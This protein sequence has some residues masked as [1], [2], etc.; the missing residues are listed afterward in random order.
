MEKG[1]N[2]AGWICSIVLLL[3]GAFGLLA[4]RGYGGYAN[5]LEFFGAFIVLGLAVNPLLL[6]SVK[7]FG[8]AYL[9]IAAGV[10]IAIAMVSY[11]SLH[12]A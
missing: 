5:S 4:E 6:R 11:A 3:A 10:I 12:A 1:L 8:H 2:L 9:T 7:L